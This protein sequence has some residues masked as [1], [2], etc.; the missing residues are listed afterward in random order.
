MATLN[1]PLPVKLRLGPLPRDLRVEIGDPPQAVHEGISHIT[2]SQGAHGPDFF[3][4]VTLDLALV[5][6]EVEGVADVE[7]ILPP[8]TREALIAL[9]WMP[10]G[11]PPAV[12]HTLSVGQFDLGK[13]ADRINDIV[14]AAYAYVDAPAYAFNPEL[15]DESPAHV[16]Y[17]HLVGCVERHRT[18]SRESSGD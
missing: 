11:G 8:N 15:E 3:P 13:A 7:V 2:V 5:A 17:E 9:G 10:P 18:L 1:N 6:V 16:A 14:Q 12:M 4:H